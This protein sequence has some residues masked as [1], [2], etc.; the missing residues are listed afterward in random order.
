MAMRLALGLFL[1]EELAAQVFVDDPLIATAAPT[2]RERQ[3][4]MLKLFFFWT[5]LGF[6]MNWKKLQFGSCVQ[7]IGAGLVLEQRGVLVTLSKSKT[8]ALLETL[9][10]LNT[11]RR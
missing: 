1:P 2:E 9:D 11:D 3:E 6:A 8:A 4:L 10:Q 7:W 5:L